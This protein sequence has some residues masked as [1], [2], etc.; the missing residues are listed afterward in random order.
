MRTREEALV[1]NYALRARYANA[2]MFIYV[3]LSIR[4]VMRVRFPHKAAAPTRFP[5]A[6]PLNGWGIKPL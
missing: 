4:H 6:T 2:I 5:S 1:S 3:D